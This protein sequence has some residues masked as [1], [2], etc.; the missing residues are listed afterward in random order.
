MLF[1]VLKYSIAKQTSSRQKAW[2]AVIVPPKGKNKSPTEEKKWKTTCNQLEKDDFSGTQTQTQ[3]GRQREHKTKTRRESIPM[4]QKRHVHGSKNTSR[5]SQNF[6]SYISQRSEKKESRGTNLRLLFRAREK[7]EK[8]EKKRRIEIVIGCK[9]GV[10]DCCS[11]KKLLLQQGTHS[12]SAD[13]L[14]KRTKDYIVLATISF[15]KQ[16]TNQ[17]REGKKKILSLS[18]FLFLSLL[19]FWR[20]F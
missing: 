6:R 7:R 5:I 2:Q 20:H 11:K 18:L 10:E 4:N 13:G 3:T 8:R 16:K 12:T 19:S 1:R 15:W 14:P 9:F 17:A